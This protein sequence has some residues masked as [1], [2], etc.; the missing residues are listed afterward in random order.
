MPLTFTAIS[1][2][3]RP[4]KDH[5]TAVLTH[6]AGT[7]GRAPDNDLVL[8]DPEKIVSRFHA[9]I[10]YEKGF[11]YITDTSL[12]GTS[13]INRGI[14]LNR[15]TPQ[16][17]A[18]LENGDHLQ[19]G[20]YELTVSVSEEHELPPP[21]PQVDYLRDPLSSVSHPGSDTTQ[22]N[23]ELESLLNGGKSSRIDIFSNSSINQ[24][25]HSHAVDYLRGPA[26]QESFTPPETESSPSPAS[27]QEMIPDD[28]NLQ[29]LLNSL[30]EPED[31]HQP[32]DFPNI[33]PPPIENIPKASACEV[34]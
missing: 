29:D 21:L 26:H 25:A 33:P 23:L 34:T 24:S 31:H 6:N 17:T 12:A 27:K 5:T 1:Y 13:I 15:N 9:S 2:R 10:H 28:F 18:R 14:T 3:G 8:T 7:I 32:S 11:F 30:E 20:D 22:D 4:P 16:E 19:V